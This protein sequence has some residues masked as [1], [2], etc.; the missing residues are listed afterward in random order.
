MSKTRVYELAKEL[1]LENKAVIQL[2]EDLGIS[3]KK[4]HSS[5]MSDDESDR[6]RRSVIRQAVGERDAT[7]QV[8][9]EGTVLEEKRVG[10]VIRRRKKS[11]EDGPEGVPQRTIDLDGA[12]SHDFQSLTPDPIADRDQ[13]NEALAMANAL[14]RT[15]KPAVTDESDSS[16]EDMREA[17][18]AEADV[19][20]EASSDAAPSLEAAPV[21]EKSVVT[22]PSEPVRPVAVT[23]ASAQ[24]PVL[25]PASKPGE[26]DFHAGVGQRPDV[27]GARVLGRIELRQPPAPAATP[28]RA[29]A[30]SATAVR[31]DSASTEEE[32]AKNSQNLK[33]KK[34]KITV[35][36]EDADRLRRKKKQVLQS[37]DLLDY[38]SERDGWRGRKDKRKRGH[39][40]DNQSSDVGETRASKKVVKIQSEISVGEIAKI[41][42]AKV[43]DLVKHLMN[44][45]I[46]AGIN[47]L[48]DVDTAT[49]IAAE[50]GFTVT[51]TAME[52]EDVMDDFKA[53]DDPS[54]LELRP[55]VVTVMGH[56]DHGK[57]SLLDAIRKT[58]VTK[59]EA[60]GIT[61]H[62]GAYT[63]A[64]ANGA[65]TFLD[66]PG[67][68]AFTA[69]RSRGAKV[70]DIVV[71]VVAADD[72]VMPQTIE[73]INHAK[74]AAVP[75]IVAINKID[76]ES[77][78]LDRVKN[79]LAEFGL[80]P[81]EWGGETIYCPVSAHSKV[82]IPELLEN[83][84]IQAEVLELK[85]N[86]NRAAVGTVVESKIDRGRGPVMTV[87]VQNGTLRKGDCFVAGSVFG[88]VRALVNDEGQS[89]DFAGPSMPV[90]VLGAGT[91]P[92]AGDDFVAMVD[93]SQ[94]REIAEMRAARQRQKDLL[95]KGGVQVGGNLTLEKFSQ[96][97]GSGE[98]K[99]LPLIVKG[100]VQGSVEAVTASLLELSDGEVKVRVLHRAV[101]AVNETDVQ[102]ASASR[103]I[104]VAF[105]IR[106][107]TRAL[108]IAENDAVEIVYS[109]VI[110]ELVDSIRAAMKGLLDPKF[111]E[112]TLGRVEVR[113]TF[114][115]PR[116][117]LVAGSYVVDGVVERNSLVRLLRDNRVVYEGK[118]ASLRRF[119]D[120]V[121]EVAAGYE[122]GIGIEG[123]N[124]I[125]NGDI[126]EIY[127]LEQVPH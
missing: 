30:P 44:L 74:A 126:I 85:A 84:H 56:V 10:N 81:E 82:G 60:G 65:V 101:G 34:R 127:K 18:A 49:L 58:T 51:N 124:D 83:L 48:L 23:A 102:L 25:P 1:G 20:A 92:L 24:A 46:M 4:S 5:T 61:Q 118:M 95:L 59:S 104:I 86:P 90:E 94:A 32:R 122:C 70:T 14:F 109:R 47:N 80:I 19:E 21:N 12:P 103:A 99:E 52:S 72:G 40:D 63:V 22:S 36:E 113:E 105:N 31:P 28:A 108:A 41:M 117:G 55:P 110:Y 43:G 107:D 91:A 16:D 29:S 77:A 62:I 68:Q 87:L 123:Y 42:G 37:N 3:G 13:R 93:E 45:G 100:D 38:D 97:I 27:R 8:T 64:V 116:L 106:A 11:D 79:Q 67:H 69:M 78:N 114:K 6:V 35:M 2:C 96:M 66:T 88:K 112:T 33:S 39:R 17:P 98:M 115:V 50:F 15:D 125:K 111:Q 73:A 119:K 76:K 9:R 75:I 7:R 121:K 57:T 89:V 71:L 120:D 54:L 26:V 53:V